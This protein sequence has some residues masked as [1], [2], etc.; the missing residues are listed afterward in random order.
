MKLRP[1]NTGNKLGYYKGYYVFIYK[2]PHGKWCCCIGKKGE[3][4][5]SE[6]YFSSWITT[7][8]IAKKWAINQITSPSIILKQSK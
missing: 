8:S 5:W 1:L 3:W 6:G 2:R 7:I 4:L